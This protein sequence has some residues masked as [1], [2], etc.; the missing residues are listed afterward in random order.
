MEVFIHT[1][2]ASYSHG[3]HLILPLPK[4]EVGFSCTIQGNFYPLQHLRKGF[5]YM[6]PDVDM[7]SYKDLELKHFASL[8]YKVSHKS[9]N[10]CSITTITS[11]SAHIL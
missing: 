3:Q 8:V 4:V 10:I 7:I 2:D 1:V 5:S 11:I 6:L 9:T